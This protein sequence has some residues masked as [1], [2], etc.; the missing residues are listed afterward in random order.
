MMICILHMKLK[1]PNIMA[2]TLHIM[3]HIHNIMTKLEKFCNVR[4][5]SYHEINN[6]FHLPFY[7]KVVPFANLS[8]MNGC[9]ILMTCYREICLYTLC[10]LSI[11]YIFLFSPP[12]TIV[13]PNIIIFYPA[14]L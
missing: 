10:T 1:L 14:H 7:D 12:Q 6:N 5:T 11:K 13:C 9:Y 4:N 2:K 3:V 8:S